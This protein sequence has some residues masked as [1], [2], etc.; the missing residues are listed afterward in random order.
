MKNLKDRSTDELRVM[1]GRAY[2]NIGIHL[3]YVEDDE[4][5]E[6]ELYGV[7]EQAEDLI[8]FSRE[9]LSRLEN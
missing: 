4:L 1:L 7:L 3:E 2:R 5:L 6:Q 9:I 8:R